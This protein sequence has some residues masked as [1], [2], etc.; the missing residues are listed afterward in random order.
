MIAAG[1]VSAT[2][3]DRSRTTNGC[4]GSGR[5]ASLG[6]RARARQRV[7]VQ[8]GDEDRVLARQPARVRERRRHPTDETDRCADSRARDAIDAA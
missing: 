8:L 2:T 6:L 7:E 4:R 1:K 5:A 3:I